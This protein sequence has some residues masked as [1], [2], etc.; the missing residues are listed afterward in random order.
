MDARGGAILGDEVGAGKTFVSFALIADVLL[1]DPKRGV[2]IFVPNR[3]LV[4]KWTVQLRDYLI[5]SIHDRKVGRALADR[6]HPMDRALRSAKRNAIVITT[7]SVYSYRTSEGDQ[8][9][10]LRAALEILPEGRGRHHNAVLKAFGLGQHS[11]DFW[12]SWAHA[13]ALNKTT[14]KPLAPLLQRYREGERGMQIDMRAA[15]QDVRR[16]VGRR[17]LRDSGLVII[18]EAH[19]LKPTSSAI[20]RSLMGVL[21]Q[22][23]DALLFLTATPFQLGRHELLTILDFF[24]ASRLHKEYP[25]AFADQRQALSDAMDDHVD[26]L[27]RFGKSWRDLTREHVAQ[28]RA[29]IADDTATEFD[30][31][32]ADVEAAFPRCRRGQGRVAVGDAPVRRPVSPRARPSRDRPC[33]RPPPAGSYSLRIG[34]SAARRNHAGGPNHHLVSADRGLLVVAGIAERSDH[35][36]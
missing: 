25:T 20:Y 11:G 19:N 21:D 13:S 27:K 31:L 7:H 3:L 29:A 36:I 8:G 4:N 5:A 30:P 1:R 15:V 26:A 32:I 16:L 18:D 6:I 23:F 28:A 12:P 9:A 2:V 17:A 34:G 14:L 33:R 22:H 35:A 10:C 24:K